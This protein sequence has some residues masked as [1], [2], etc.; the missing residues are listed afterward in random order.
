MLSNW[1]QIVGSMKR[2]L[3]VFLRDKAVIGSSFL[4]PIFFLLALPVI[5]FND[6]PNGVLSS[7]KVYLVIAM[8]VLLI[9]TTGMSNLAG[10][11]AA[12][13]GNELYSKLS[14]MPVNP[15]CELIGRILTVIV[16]SS[17]GS[18]MLIT[19][20][21]LYGTQTTFVLV[22]MLLSIGIGFLIVISSVG[23]GLIISSLV[24][25]E[26]AAAH[27]G[28]AIVMLIYF[29]GIAIPYNDLPFE[30]QAFARFN[31]ISSG[32]N[33]ISFLILGQDFVGYNPLNF[34]D[35]GLFVVSCSVLIILGIL[36]YFKSCWR[37]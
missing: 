34:I 9:M 31:P 7:L 32:N 5:F 30:L 16:F 15:F 11:I 20:G 1:S 24:K 3:W 10:S 26:S 6:V 4:M 37:Q 17:I 19:L 25:T 12:D 8:I 14:S 33:M 21:I 18:V 23:I 27:V 13:R 29:I 35:I 28:V 2:S 36:A 22:D